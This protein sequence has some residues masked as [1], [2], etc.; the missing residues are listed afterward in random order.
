[1]PSTSNVFYDV[2]QGA[3]YYDAV[4]YVTQSGLMTGGSDKQFAPNTI[5]SRA[6]VVQILYA[7]AGGPTVSASND[8]AD[9]NRGDWYADAVSWA[10]ANGVVSGMGKEM[11]G[12]NAPLTREQLALILYHYAQVAEYVPHQG[13][14]AVQKFSDS[15]S[16]SGWALEAV[17]WA[18]NAG[19]IS[20]TGG[21]MLDPDGTATRAQVAQIFMNFCQDNAIE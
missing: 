1:M 12:P 5:L 18:V 15:A 3:W 21:G 9:L 16:I 2:A 7:L 17:Q 11:F 8:F 14:M 10:T 19:L 20:G 4:Q 13:S 6:Q